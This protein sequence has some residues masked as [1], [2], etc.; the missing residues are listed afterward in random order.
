[1]TLS[2]ENFSALTKRR[3]GEGGRALQVPTNGDTVEQ[4]RVQLTAIGD[5]IRALQSTDDLGPD[6]NKKVYAQEQKL[7]E[8]FKA[9]EKKLKELEEQ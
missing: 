9:I 4:L 7:W 1:M 8:N 3:L 2:K 6:M 5:G